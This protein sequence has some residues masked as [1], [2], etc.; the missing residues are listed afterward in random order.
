MCFKA[1][2]SI[3]ILFSTFSLFP[4]IYGRLCQIENHRRWINDN[5]SQLSDDQDLFHCPRPEDPPQFTDCCYSDSQ[6][7]PATGMCCERKSH[8]S[9]LGFGDSMLIAISVGV[10]ISCLLSS[11]LVL[12]CCFC[13][14]CPLYSVCHSKYEHND[15]I[16][17]STKEEL[18]KLNG[19]PNEDYK[20]Q[21]GYEPN[22][23][24]VRPVLY[25]A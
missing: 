3:A 21:Q 23:V 16:A 5:T 12:V 25:D 4:C 10:I 11:I 24:Q 18:M 15:T 7:V 13:S 20:I 17:F 6:A 14:K 8:D 2:A 1:F 22:A 19:M 9:M